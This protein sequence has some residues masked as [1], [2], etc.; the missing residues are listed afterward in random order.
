MGCTVGANN[1]QRLAGGHFHEFRGR[2]PRQL[3]HLILVRDCVTTTL[4]LQ[5]PRTRK[6]SSLFG[7][8][9]VRPRSIPE[10]LNLSRENIVQANKGWAPMRLKGPPLHT[11]YISINEFWA[12]YPDQLA[13]RVFTKQCISE[14]S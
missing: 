6:R 10:P 12:R 5:K 8:T 11:H 2:L 1:S 4:Q 7:R 14:V 9:K 13:S 3:S